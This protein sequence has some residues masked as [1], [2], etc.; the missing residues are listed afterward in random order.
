MEKK[1]Q[2]PEK[3]FLVHIFTGAQSPCEYSVLRKICMKHGLTCWDIMNGYIPWRNK[4]TLRC[5]VIRM[6]RKQALS[7]YT[8]LRADPNRIAEDNMEFIKNPEKMKEAGFCYKGGMLVNT[9]S[10]SK[11]E[12]NAVKSRNFAKYQLSQ[13]ESDEIVI[14]SVISADYM[15]QRCFRRRQSLLLYRAALRA[16]IARREGTE[17]PDLGVEELQLR[18]G[19]EVIIPRASTKLETMTK[20]E[21]FFYDPK[22]SNGKPQYE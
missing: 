2:E 19:T 1:H 7:E 11:E 10:R 18:S 9:V 8:G 13:E 12:W 21:N 20:L 15:K 14:P 4:Q 17:C 3:G 6:I 16:E 5:F 22:P